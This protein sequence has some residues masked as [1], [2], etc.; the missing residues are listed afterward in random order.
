MYQFTFFEIS[1]FPSGQLPDY[2]PSDKLWEMLFLIFVK[3]IH[4]LEKK[5]LLSKH[6]MLSRSAQDLNW[7]WLFGFLSQMLAKMIFNFQVTKILPQT[8]NIPT[9]SLPE[10]A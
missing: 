3:Y 4:N 6:V 8:E 5:K 1:V 9:K 2:L 10:T 7:V